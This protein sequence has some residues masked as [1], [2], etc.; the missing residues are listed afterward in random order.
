MSGTVA[1]IQK[2]TTLRYDACGSIKPKSLSKPKTL[3]QKTGNAPKWFQGHKRNIFIY[4]HDSNKQTTRNH[5]FDSH[6]LQHA[7]FCWLHV[8]HTSTL[9]HA[10]LL[11]FS[12]Y[13]VASRENLDVYLYLKEVQLIYYV[14]YCVFY[15]VFLKKKKIYE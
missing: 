13:A 3:P 11:S 4:C 1:N 7:A 9:V 5:R 10:R 12:S 14:Q 15:T 6:K 8:I 2:K